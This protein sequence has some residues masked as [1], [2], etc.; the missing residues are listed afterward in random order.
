MQVL[1]ACHDPGV[2]AAFLKALRKADI[3]AE[4]APDG[5]AALEL[6]RRHRP[7]IVLLDD[8]LPGLPAVLGLQDTGG[9]ASGLGRRDHHRPL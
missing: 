7:D 8:E 1:V 6:A 4:T 2:V 9:R 3:S 5:E